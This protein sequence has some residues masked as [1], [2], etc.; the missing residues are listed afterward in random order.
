MLRP[1]DHPARPNGYTP[2]DPV[3]RHF[4]YRPLDGAIARYSWTDVGESEESAKP[5][6]YW[7]KPL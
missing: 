6:Q 1:D 5:M 4:G 3:W 2:L 7:I